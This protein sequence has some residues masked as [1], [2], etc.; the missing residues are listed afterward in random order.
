ML[1]S[2]SIKPARYL[3]RHNRRIPTHLTSPPLPQPLPL[4]T[5]TQSPTPTTP[6]TST[7]STSHPATTTPRPPHILQIPTT[8]TS[9]IE[10]YAAETATRPYANR[11]TPDLINSLMVFQA[12]GIPAVVEAAPALLEAAEK[13]GVEG[14]AHKVVKHTF[15]KHFCGG[16][17]L[18]EVH[19]TM[20]QFKS[21][22]VGSILDLAIE[23][24]VEDE[25]ESSSGPTSQQTAEKVTKMVLEGIDTAS[26]QTGS[27]FAVKITSLVSPIIL[28]HWSTTLRLLKSAFE[29]ADTNKDGKISKE[30]FENLTSTFPSL[31]SKTSDLSK[32]LDH[33]SDNQIDWINLSD[34]FSLRHP[35]HA[36]LLITPPPPPPRQHA[37]RQGPG[38][39]TPAPRA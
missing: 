22:N 16:E 10:A 12:C 28:Q 8:F 29:K 20:E 39:K 2:K 18:S 21:Q 15:F 17:N 14:V 30:E 11:S 33:D 25:D 37:T 27:M 7:S 19:A 26:Q 35:S 32:T 23:A 9:S 31:K 38:P 3:L 6:P 5:F 36:S 1:P 13:L 34:F 24:D 4:R